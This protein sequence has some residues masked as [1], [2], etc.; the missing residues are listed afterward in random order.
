MPN[1]FKFLEEKE[2]PYA[3]LIG[4]YDED[5]LMKEDIGFR[6]DLDIVLDCN[7]EDV[8]PFLKENSNFKYLQNNSFLAHS[9]N[10]RIDL[11]FKTLNV[12]YYGFLNINPIAFRS[13]RISETE[14]IIYQILDPLL[15]FSKYKKRHVYRLKQYFNNGISDDV[16][17]KMRQIIGFRLTKIVLS[18]ISKSD[19]SFTESF[20]KR[21]KFRMLFING[22]FVKMI[23]LRIF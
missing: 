13:K 5:S 4:A 10:L 22:N 17:I 12:G 7:K 19:F 9:D 15:K 21:C 16:K 6:D 3:V 2:I 11:Y 18:K 1:I 20:I 23:R 14:Y 8:I